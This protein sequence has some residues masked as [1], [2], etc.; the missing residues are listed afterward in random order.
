MNFDA[1]FLSV[2]MGVLGALWVRDGLRNVGAH[3]RKHNAKCKR[4]AEE[5]NRLMSEASKQGREDTAKQYAG[6][7]RY[8]TEQAPYKVLGW[9]FSR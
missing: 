7:Y 8:W 6:Q 2:F 9:W 1:S 5:Y 4:E 3:V